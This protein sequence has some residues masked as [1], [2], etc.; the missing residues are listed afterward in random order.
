LL[1]ARGKQQDNSTETDR[2][3]GRGNVNV[4]RVLKYG[5]FYR[6]ILKWEDRGKRA[7]IRENLG[8]NWRVER[9]LTANVTVFKDKLHL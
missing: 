6:K 9:G 8:K 4:M 1:R 2:S 5:I 3:D 7:Q